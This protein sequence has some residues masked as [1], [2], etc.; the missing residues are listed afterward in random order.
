MPEGD[1]IYRSAAAL[2]TALI[3]REMLAFDAPRLVGLKPGVGSTIDAVTSYGKHLEITWSDGVTIR[4]HMRM[5]GSWHLYRPGERWRMPRRDARVVIVTDAWEAVCFRAPEVESYRSHPNVTPN[6]LA[7]LGPDLT[8]P[9]AD[10]GVCID[11]LLAFAERDP[12]DSIADVLLDQ[13]V[14]CGVGNVFKSEVLFA[15]RVNPFTAVSA[16]DR[17]VATALIATAHRMLLANLDSTRRTTVTAEQAAPWA[18]A[19]TLAV[20]GRA[21]QLCL[22]CRTPIESRRHGKHQRSN[23]WCPTC[24][25]SA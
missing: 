5:V 16:I 3:G 25:P 9:D 4:S 7:R 11:R 17:P 23:Y 15:C 24:Q 18:N 6:A 20:Y 12:A 21:R 22:V 10:E 13:R 14:A 8:R 2:R 1:T 19:P